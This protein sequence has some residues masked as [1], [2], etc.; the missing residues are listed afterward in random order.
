MGENKLGPALFI[1]LGIFGIYLVLT[2][3]AQN[4]INA[5]NGTGSSSGSG[6]STSGS[7][8]AD[9][10]A[11]SYGGYAVTPAPSPGGSNGINALSGVPQQGGFG[12]SAQ[13]PAIAAANYTYGV[14]SSYD[15]AV[16]AASNAAQE[17]LGLYAG[18]D[19]LPTSTT[20]VPGAYGFNA[21]SL[22]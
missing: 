5:A 8:V 9:P 20:T 21:L 14:G 7:G 17:E 11:G 22:A 15:Q 2:G 10:S 6:S 12:T 16:A 3:K 4:L 1:A 19:P 18:A 13:N